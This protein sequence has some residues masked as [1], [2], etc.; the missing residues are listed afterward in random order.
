LLTCNVVGLFPDSGRATPTPVAMASA[1]PAQH[2]AQ[3]GVP[4]LQ[5]QLLTPKAQAP[6]RGS[7]FAAGYDLYSS[8]DNVVPARGKAMIATGIAIAVPAGTCTLHSYS[9]PHISAPP[10][11]KTQHQSHHWRSLLSNITDIVLRWP[12][13]PAIRL[14]C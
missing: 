3:E 8:E 11:K 2:G 9:P 10:G 4:S 14:S 13:R 7:A 12:C 1:D 6:T 5:V